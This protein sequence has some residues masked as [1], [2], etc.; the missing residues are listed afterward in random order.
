VGIRNQKSR[1]DEER[2]PERAGGTAAV[3]EVDEEYRILRGVID[4]LCFITGLPG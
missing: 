4:S 2:T 1:G 3:I